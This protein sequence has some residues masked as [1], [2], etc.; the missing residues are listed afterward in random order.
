ML[1]VIVPIYNGANYI[2]KCI[3][4]ILNQEYKDFEIICVDDGSSDNSLQIIAGLAELDT[5][6]K[7]IHKEENEGLVSARKTGVNNAKGNY[8][9][10]VDCDDWIDGKMYSEM[11]TYAEKYNADVVTTGT[12]YEGKFNKTSYDG[13][14]EGLYLGEKLDI[15]KEHIFFSNRKYE[16]GIRSNLVNKIYR[17]GL[18]K[19]IQNSISDNVFYGEDRL[20]SLECILKADS[21]YVLHKAYYHYV[22]YDKSMSCGENLFYLDQIGLLYR[23]L[24]KAITN[25]QYYEQLRYQCGIYITQLLF[26]GLN[27]N[28]GIEPKDIVWIHPSWVS[29]IPNNSRIILYGCGRRGK[30]YYRQIK[31]SGMNLEIVGWVDKNYQYFEDSVMDIKNPRMILELEYDYILITVESEKATEEIIKF[32]ENIGVK[33]DRVIRPLPLDSFW[34]YAESAGLYND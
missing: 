33:R 22:L 10:Y 3:Q 19:D 32:L 7:I 31:N 1:S 23:E 12:I 13:F 11:I 18:I 5:R 8:V 2:N 17:I 29:D 6:I 26:K 34:E 20:C 4:S 15:I 14:D 30:T 9:A 27:D 25:T 21:I 28:M 16:E 24:L